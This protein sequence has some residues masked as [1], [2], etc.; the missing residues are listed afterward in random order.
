VYFL[1]R[2]QVGK[3]ATPISV[4]SARMPVAFL[5]FYG[6]DVRNENRAEYG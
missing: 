1:T 2:R 6:K 3:V 4:F 5:T